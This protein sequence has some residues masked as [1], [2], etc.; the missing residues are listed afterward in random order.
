MTTVMTMMTMKVTTMMLNM[1]TMTMTMVT[2]MMMMMMM[3]M[4]VMVMVM[5]MF[6]TTYKSIRT[7]IGHR[8]RQ[9]RLPIY[10]VDRSW[11]RRSSYYVS[12]IVLLLYLASCY[13]CTWHAHPSRSPAVDTQSTT[14]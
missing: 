9:A 11:L 2:V 5:V 10:A 12:G 14:R 7:V 13:F 6:S 4:M 8:P 3:M 1:R